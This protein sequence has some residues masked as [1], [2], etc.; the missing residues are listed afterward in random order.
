MPHLISQIRPLKVLRI[1][2]KKEELFLLK[3]LGW[4]Y[5]MVQNKYPTIPQRPRGE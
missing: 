4:H 2:L 5:K 3:D 1:Y